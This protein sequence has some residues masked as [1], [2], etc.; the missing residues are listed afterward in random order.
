MRGGRVSYFLPFTVY[1][2]ALMCYFCNVKILTTTKKINKLTNKPIHCSVWD[3]NSWLPESSPSCFSFSLKCTPAQGDP[4]P[5]LRQAAPLLGVPLL[6]P[7]STHVLQTRTQRPPPSR[8]HAGP[9]HSPS[10]DSL[11]GPSRPRGLESQL[12]LHSFMPPMFVFCVFLVFFKKF[13]FSQ[14]AGWGEGAGSGK[15]QSRS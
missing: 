8:S 2:F 7:L 9:E 10:S 4:S 12:A 15:H 14:L 11:C 13:M 3:M 5:L 6:Y 1:N